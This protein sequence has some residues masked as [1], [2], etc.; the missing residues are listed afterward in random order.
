MI[1]DVIEIG[2]PDELAYRVDRNGTGTEASLDVAPS[3]VLSSEKTQ[4]RFEIRSNV[5]V[6]ED[7]A[8]AVRRVV[9][10]A[11]VA[12]V[13]IPGGSPSPNADDKAR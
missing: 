1:G 9:E 12:R 7:E 5:E 13:I 2:L 3:K 6:L 10:L 4:L 11:L 8:V